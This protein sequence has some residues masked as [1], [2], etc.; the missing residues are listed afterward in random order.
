MVDRMAMQRQIAIFRM[1]TA[2]K[3]DPPHPVAVDFAEHADAAGRCKQLKRIMR[4]QHP[5]RHAVRQAMAEDEKGPP[6]FS[7]AISC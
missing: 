1:L 3:V 6:A 2:V 4:D 7:S 5:A